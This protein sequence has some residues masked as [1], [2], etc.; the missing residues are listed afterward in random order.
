MTP[1]QTL[2]VFLDKYDPAIAKIGRAVLRAMRGLVPGAVELVYDNYNALG[3]GYAPT[4]RPNGIFLSVVLYPRWV[5]LFFFE[6]VSLRDPGKRL[7]GSGTRIRHI[8]LEAG[9]ATLAE[10]EVLDLIQQA[11]AKA[12]PPLARSGRGKL[13]IQSVSAKQKPRRANR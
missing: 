9:A 11:V 1:K 12:D 6:G 7:K 5:S 2:D 10:P 8:V 4:E 3:V 13:V